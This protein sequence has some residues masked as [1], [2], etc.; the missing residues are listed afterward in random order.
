MWSIVT[1]SWPYLAP[2]PWSETWPP[3]ITLLLWENVI[4]FMMWSL[5]THCGEQSR[6]LPFL[7]Y[8]L[9]NPL[10]H[11]LHLGKMWTMCLRLEAVHGLDLSGVSEHHHPKCIQR[12]QQMYTSSLSFSWKVCYKYI[13]SCFWNENFI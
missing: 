8:R 12:G 5:G 7:K 2:T 3:I 6:M 10:Y 13:Q 9:F 11:Q 4:H 1:I